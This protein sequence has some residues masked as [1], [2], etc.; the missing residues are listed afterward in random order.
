MYTILNSVAF[1]KIKKEINYLL[2]TNKYIM[3][4]LANNSITII[5]INECMCTVNSN[6]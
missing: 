5:L 3:I 1:L 6:N 4:N 2:V